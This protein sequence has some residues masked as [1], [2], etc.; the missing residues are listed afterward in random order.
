MQP[1]FMEPQVKLSALHF[2]PAPL[3]ILMCIAKFE[4]TALEK[5]DIPPTKQ[6]AELLWNSS[7]GMIRI[8]LM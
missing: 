6:R 4:T 3:I 2:Y 1:K 7:G 8:E 5:L